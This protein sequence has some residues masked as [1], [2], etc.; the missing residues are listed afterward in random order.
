MDH[1]II[2]AATLDQTHTTVMTTGT[3]AVGLDH[4]PILADITT[5]VAMTH[6]EAVPGHTTE[7]TDDIT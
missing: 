3:D 6:T 4:I 2:V 5:K 7:I 1:N